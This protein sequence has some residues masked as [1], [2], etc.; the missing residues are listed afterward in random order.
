MKLLKDGIFAFLFGKIVEA[1][2]ALFARGEGL[3]FL[4][5]QEVFLFAD[6]VHATSFSVVRRCGGGR[7]EVEGFLFDPLCE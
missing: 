3:W 1:R 4:F 5:A 6:T 7:S 2:D